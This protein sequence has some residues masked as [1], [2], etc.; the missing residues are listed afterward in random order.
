MKRW[1]IMLWVAGVLFVVAMPAKQWYD[2]KNRV[3]ALR[4]EATELQSELTELRDALAE[5]RSAKVTEAAARSRLG[6]VRPGER[7]Y[8]VSEPEPR[9]DI[10]WIDDPIEP[11]GEAAWRRVFGSLGRVLRALI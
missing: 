11:A 7:A 10:P 5:V 3:A 9:R 1:T 4:A 6:M 8:V 2:G